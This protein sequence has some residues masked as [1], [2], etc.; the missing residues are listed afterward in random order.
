MQ[1]NASIN[2]LP[3]PYEDS[4]DDFMPRLLIVGDA[5]I[6][7]G[8]FQGE[9]EGRGIL[10]DTAVIGEY[11][12]AKMRERQY[13]AVICDMGFSG[14]DRFISTC[15]GEFPETRLV[16]LCESRRDGGATK[17]AGTPEIIEK[18]LEL[19]KLKAIFGDLLDF[20]RDDL[21]EII[22]EP[23]D[24]YKFV[25]KLYHRGL[26]A[27]LLVEK[28]GARYAMK[29]LVKHLYSMENLKRFFRE[30]G[31]LASLDHPNI[32]RIYEYGLSEKGR[33][34]YMVMEHVEGRNLQEII[35]SGNMPMEKRISVLK[36][37]AS[38]LDAVH[39]RSVLHRDIKPQN[40]IVKDDGLPKLA[41]FGV[42]HVLDSKLTA[43][44]AVLGT[45]AYM[46]PE[47][48]ESGVREDERSDIFSLGT[49]GYELLTGKYPFSLVSMPKTAGS[50]RN[51]RPVEP[52]KANPWIH[53]LI[54]VVLGR[55]LEKSP[56]RRYQK[57]SEIVADIEEYDRSKYYY[58]FSLPRRISLYLK[59]RHCWR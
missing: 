13:L 20:D 6:L 41:D 37:L 38:A 42:A 22:Y 18:P 44:G 23:P 36:Q 12:L 45:P 35:K 17:Y 56:A 9:M 53:P 49:V 8:C 46:A 50:I 30:A 15:R 54:Q 27:V 11:A 31:V 43:S 19:S 25:R 10:L 5:K 24:G 47:K 34:P 39:G 3:T 33:I 2:E 40:V 29:V 26:Y 7:Q 51:D 14:A 28:D 1:E 32:T 21:A 52:M 57:A 16:L 59:Y 48:F 55:M 58:R 4:S